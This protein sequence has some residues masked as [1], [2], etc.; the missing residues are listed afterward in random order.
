MIDDRET[1]FTH[2]TVVASVGQTK[3]SREV[4]IVLGD[5]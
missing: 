2:A 1:L 4:G 5:R 3:D